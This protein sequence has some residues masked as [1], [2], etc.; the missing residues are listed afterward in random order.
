MCGNT[1]EELF[2]K[3]MSTSGRI[4][5]LLCVV[6]LQ[7]SS[8]TRLKSTSRSIS[9]LLCVVILS[10][11]LLQDKEH[12]WEYIYP[13]VCVN[14]AEEIFYKK[15]STSRSISILLCVLVLQRS[16]STQQG[17]PVGVYLPCCVCKYSR[18]ALRQ[19]KEHQ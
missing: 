7:R 17:A 16:S 13:V 10:G 5:T 1:E 12:Q 4:S 19:D 18:E 11:A 8:S 15:R 3:T 6:I 9:T 14:T 2:Y